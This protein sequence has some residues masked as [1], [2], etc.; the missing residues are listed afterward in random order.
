MVKKPKP[1]HKRTRVKRKVI[2]PS[3]RKNGK[4]WA[5]TEEEKRAREETRL[6][7]AMAGY[8]T[9]AYQNLAFLTDTQLEALAKEISDFVSRDPTWYRRESY[10]K[11]MWK[12]HLEEKMP[13]VVQ[14]KILSAD[15]DNFIYIKYTGNK[16]YTPIQITSIGYYILN[17]LTKGGL[18]T[19]EGFEFVKF[20][21]ES[22]GV[23]R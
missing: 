8:I 21:R 11:G 22:A 18:E 13:G 3:L 9:G 5:K 19:K 23:K 4:S 12:R 20:A 16:R 10:S 1:R 17:R 15:T 14:F 7:W 6:K 2:R